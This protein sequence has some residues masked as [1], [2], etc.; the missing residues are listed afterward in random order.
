MFKFKIIIKLFLFLFI[1]NCAAPGTALLAPT[2]TGAKTK[3]F[4][5][6]S[7]SLASSL[8][9]NH[10]LNSHTQ[11]IKKDLLDKIGKFKQKNIYSK[12]N[13]SLPDIPFSSENPKI[14]IA[15]V[16]DK[17]QISEISEPEPLP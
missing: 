5:Q 8:S 2:I 12:I 3:S 17:I 6:A 14:L 9:S 4:Q 11:E 13:P 16:V 15:H 10:I 1:A 7:M